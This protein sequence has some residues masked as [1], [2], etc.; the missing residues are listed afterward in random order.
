MKLP[1]RHIEE[2]AGAQRNFEQ[3]EQIWPAPPVAIRTAGVPA[4][5]VSTSVPWALADNGHIYFWNGTSWV[6]KV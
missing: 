6:V 1:V 5:S 2:S 4:A 3:L